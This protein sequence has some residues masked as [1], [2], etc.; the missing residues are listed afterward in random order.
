MG[1]Y[2][3]NDI[4]DFKQSVA[5]ATNMSLDMASIDAKINVAARRHLVPWLGLAQW[6]KLV[7]DFGSLTTEEEALLPYVQKVVEL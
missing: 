6:Q 7:D 2:I 3:F 1:H 5:G 4:V